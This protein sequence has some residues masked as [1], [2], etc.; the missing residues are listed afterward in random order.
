[1]AYWDDWTE[2]GGLFGK[3]QTKSKTEIMAPKM[4][5]E[6]EEAVGARGKWWDTLQDWGGQEGYGAIQPNWDD[7]WENARGKVRQYYGGG[8]TGPGA[9]NRMKSDAARQ[10]MSGQPSTTRSLARMGMQEGQQLQDISVEQA[11]KEAMLGEQGRRTW[12]G[13]MQSL[14]GLKPTLYSTGSTTSGTSGGGEGF[15]IIGAA[16][17]YAAGSGGGGGATPSGAGTGMSSGAMKY[18][19]ADPGIADLGFSDTDL[20]KLFSGGY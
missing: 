15:D 11:M 19:G 20:D 7:L 14:S 13:S 9:I 10:G 18:G 3:E 4:A 17:G 1:M 5:P 8:P 2:D 12:L 6:F 16:L